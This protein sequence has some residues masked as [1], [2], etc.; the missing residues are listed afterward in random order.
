[1]KFVPA[2]QHDESIITKYFREK[3]TPFY[4]LLQT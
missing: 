4:G 2:V 3:A 1:M